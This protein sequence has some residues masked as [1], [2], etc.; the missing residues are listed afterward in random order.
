MH[1]GSLITVETF[2]IAAGQ[3]EGQPGVRSRR[4]G[5]EGKNPG[6]VEQAGKGSRDVQRPQLMSAAVSMKLPDLVGAIFASMC[7]PLRRLSWQ[8][9]SRTNR[10]CGFYSIWV[11]ACRKSTL[12]NRCARRWALPKRDRKG[13]DRG[14]PAGPLHHRRT[15]RAQGRGGIAAAF[16]TSLA[17]HQQGHRAT[18]SGEGSQ[19][20]GLPGLGAAGYPSDLS[21]APARGAALSW[22]RSGC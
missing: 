1:T 18:G 11:N 9:G 21:E 8:V 4:K 19:A 17:L 3:A 13:P 7:D 22:S 20:P 15:E 5:E 6:R 12:K 16:R 2:G 10:I 14:Q